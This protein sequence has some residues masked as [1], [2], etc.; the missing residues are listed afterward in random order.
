MKLYLIG[1][2]FR[3]A[4]EQIQMSLFPEEKMEYTEQPFSDGDGTVS[5]LHIG[6]C[7]TTAVT[8]ITYHGRTVRAVRRR[9]QAGLS[10]PQCRQLLQQCYYLA[11]RQHLSEP[12]PWGAFSGVRPSKIATRHLLSGGTVAS[13]DRLLRND[14]F[15]TPAR[16]RLCI[17]AATQTVAAQALLRPYDISLY[18]GI[19]FCPTRCAYCSF[20][21]QSVQHFGHLVEPY[22][23][24]LLQE[25]AATGQAMLGTPFRIR[26]VYIGGG[27]PTT[28]SAAQL[29]RLLQAIGQHLDLSDCLEFTVEAGRPETL[30]PAKLQVLHNGGCNRLSINPQTMNDQVLR[31]IGRSHTTAQILTAY[32]EACTAGFRHINMDLIAGLPGDTEVSFARS[33]SQ[34]LALEP[35]SITVHT[36]ALKKAADL[37]GHR[38]LLPPAQTVAAMLCEAEPALRSHGYAPYYLYR[39]KYMS[40]SFENVGWCKDGYLGLYNIYMMEELQSI[41]ALGSGGVSKMNFPGGRLERLVNPKYPQEYLR[42]IDTVL[43]N[44]Q[45]FFQACQLPTNE[46]FEDD[47]TKGVAACSNYPM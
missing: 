27:T 44:K 45:A 35:A 16:R 17:E 8:T 2:T 38:E 46:L 34:V 15:I 31:A 26:T 33:L 23:A 6:S 32:Q 40:G 13:A 43:S 1:H 11:A 18:V 7:Y 28:L 3:Y 25:I 22:L 4:L 47:A 9:R 36:L 30:D 10:A 20:V 42:N 41:L 5:A 14:Y 21:S 19:P 24:A 29:Q 12:P 39:Q 37:Y